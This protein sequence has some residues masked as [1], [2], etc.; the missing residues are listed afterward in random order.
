[1]AAFM[2][3][4]VILLAVGLT[5]DLLGADTLQLPA[6]RGAAPCARRRR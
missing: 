2:Q 1:M 5:P 6:S 3:S 4:T